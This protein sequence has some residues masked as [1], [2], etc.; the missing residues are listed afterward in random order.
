[1]NT[2][3]S[4]IIPTVNAAMEL[5]L[6]LR[7]LKQN[8]D[9][10]HEYIIL[11]DPDQRTKKISSEILKICKKHN[12]TPYQNNTNLGPYG[13]WNKGAKLSKNDLLVFATD[14]QYF[15]P[16]WDAELLRNSKPGRI[17]AGRLVEPGIIPV[18][19]TNIQK[20]FGVTPS[21]FREQ[22]FLSW[23]ATQPSA[24]FTSDGFF[25]PLLILKKDFMTLGDFPASGQFG[26]RSAVSNDYLY[27][28]AA[29]QKGFQFGTAS[30]SYS[31]HFQGSSW[32]KKN[33]K[34]KIAAVVLTYNNSQT[35]SACLNSLSWV[36]KI[37]A[38]DS[39]SSDSTIK[40]LSKANVKI[41]SRP[42]DDYAKTRNFALT[43][44]RDYDWVFML[45]SDEECEPSL[46]TELR[47]AAQDIYLDGVMVRRKNYI[48]GK[49]IEH[50][51]WY[52]D[53]RLVFFRPKAIQFTSDVHE[54]AIFT[55]G[56]G[57]T[58]T[59]SNHIIHHNY[60]T[61]AEFIQKNLLTYPLVYAKKLHTEGVR[62]SPLEMLNTSLSEFMR[63]YFLCEGYKDGMHGFLL[64]VLM[65]ISQFSSYLYLWEL[66]GRK[67][68]FEYPD[69]KQLL[70]HLPKK[71]KEFR[72]WIHTLEVNNNQGIKRHLARLKRKSLKLF[73]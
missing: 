20:D 32:K 54:R 14:D 37:Y 69:F 2:G 10:S 67:Y 52:P 33:L 26:T 68:T 63:R 5:D 30:S 29:K 61:V 59:S 28:Q 56:G 72:Y 58:I 50:S 48:W 39:G 64:S 51:D 27:I 60:E 22:E 43:L 4:V 47:S 7:S 70:T 18:Y 71:I 11:V 42:F 17:T 53:T 36:N 66:Q 1:M 21:E 45:D 8:S 34:P 65:G 12:L 13:S 55:K 49:W 40:I 25:I 62:F 15:A 6:T 38:I 41:T 9:F 3:M 57:N 31:Y 23:V 44:V 46:A 16:H 24:Q 19:K 73:D 35:I